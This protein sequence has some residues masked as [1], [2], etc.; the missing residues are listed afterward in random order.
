MDGSKEEIRNTSY[1]SKLANNKRGLV[2]KCENRHFHKNQDLDSN[3][4][5]LNSYMQQVHKSNENRV[6]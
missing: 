4:M 1:C 6:E 3:E 2:Y 5:E